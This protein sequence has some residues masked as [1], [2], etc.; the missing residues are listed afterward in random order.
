MTSLITE[1]AERMRAIARRRRVRRLAVFG[2]AVTGDFD[3]ARSDIDVLVELDDLEPVERA[4]A[5]FGLLADL[6]A[7]FGR[8]VDLV[9]R[10]AI[11]NP[12]VRTTVEATQVTVY[13]AA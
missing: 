13:D 2:S 11:R 9:E 4:D 1:N 6:E 3:P 7:L 5:Y 8:P 12:V 10:S